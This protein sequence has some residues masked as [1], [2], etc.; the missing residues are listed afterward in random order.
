MS[1]YRFRSPA[2]RRLIPAGRGR[3]ARR[4]GDRELLFSTCV[5]LMATVVCRVKSSVHAAYQAQ[6]HNTASRIDGSQKKRNPEVLKRQGVAAIAATPWNGGAGN[7]TPI[8]TQSKTA[9]PATGGAESGAPVICR[10]PDADLSFLIA[11]WDRLPA[12]VRAA[13]LALIRATSG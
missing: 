10:Q 12:P 7:R 6:D 13:I 8:E 11:T 5:D 2:A 1:A 4:R 3:F 9:L